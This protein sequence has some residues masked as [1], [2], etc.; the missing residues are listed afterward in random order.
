MGAEE[1][2][3][4][5]GTLYSTKT[6]RF[7]RHAEHV[8]I[9]LFRKNA[10]MTS[11]SAQMG[12]G[13]C[14]SLPLSPPTPTFTVSAFKQNQDIFLHLPRNLQP[15][16]KT[17]SVTYTIQ[18]TIAIYWIHPD[19]HTIISLYVKK[20]RILLEDELLKGEIL[21]PR[22]TIQTTKAMFDF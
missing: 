7:G 10:R 21:Q 9:A 22:Q 20:I 3:I 15:H 6:K 4:N 14:C 13:Q 17:S 1:P 18:N 19:R 2:W 5:G 12:E 11:M 16:E 8:A